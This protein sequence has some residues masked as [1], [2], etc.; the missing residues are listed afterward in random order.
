MPY[1]LVPPWQ[2]QLNSRKRDI[3]RTL[4]A[5][6]LWTQ[7]CRPEPK[8]PRVDPEADPIGPVPPDPAAAL[9][10]IPGQI[11]R[12]SFQAKD[13][14]EV[15]RKKAMSKWTI[16]LHRIPKKHSKLV[17]E[18]DEANNQHE[19]DAL[20]WAAL[21]KGAPS[22]SQQR[23]GPISFYIAWCDE[24]QVAPFPLSARKAYKYC[25]YLNDIK[26]PATRAASFMSAAHYAIERFTMST[27]HADLQVPTVEGAVLESYDR[28]KL[29][30]HAPQL[31]VHTICALERAACDKTAPDGKQVVAGFL[32]YCVGARLRLGDARRITSEPYIDPPDSVGHNSLDSYLEVMAKITKTSRLSGRRRCPLPIVCHTFG[33]HSAKW[34][35]Q[36][37]R[38]RRRLRLHAATNGTLMPACGVEDRS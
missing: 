6:I 1:A 27:S 2:H 10:T 28:K 33:L 11:R 8:A 25:K 5:H 4:G 30:H 35:T 19:R 32:R 15:A 16:I 9:A 31:S 3:G 38:A 26:A 14:V 21:Y 12:P 24:R 7:P 22:T 29:T 17:E 36:W 13:D 37:L 20:L 34:A 18:M 23:A